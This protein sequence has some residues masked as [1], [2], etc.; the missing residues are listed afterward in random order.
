MVLAHG[1][2]IF[3]VHAQH[4]ASLALKSHLPVVFYLSDFAE[5]GGFVSY[6]PSYPD[7]FR[8]AAAYVDKILKGVK[9][10]DIPVEQPQ[11]FEL[12]V[13]AKTA[14][15]FGLSIPTPLLLRADRVIE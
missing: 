2:P 3:H 8:R 4:L 13:N 1:D 6:A 5:Y 10:G 9:P 15:A 7:L 14:R 12:V 11:K